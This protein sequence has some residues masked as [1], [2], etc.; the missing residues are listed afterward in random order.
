MGS[1]VGVLP[2]QGCLTKVVMGDESAGHRPVRELMK[3]VSKVKRDATWVD[4][5]PYEARVERTREQYREGKHNANSARF[6][7]NQH[8]ARYYLTAPV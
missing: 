6:G 3:P 8:G 1:I 4:S 7:P 2:E 5:M